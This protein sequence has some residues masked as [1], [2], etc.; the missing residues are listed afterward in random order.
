MEQ[1][2]E[3]TNPGSGLFYGLIMAQAL[4]AIAAIAAYRLWLALLPVR[5]FDI[6]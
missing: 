1:A 3:L 2:Q 6:A 4:A 5:A